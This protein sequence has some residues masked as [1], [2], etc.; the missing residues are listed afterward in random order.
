MDKVK[1]LAFNNVDRAEPD[2]LWRLDDPSEG[3]RFFQYLMDNAEFDGRETFELKELT[4]AEW[5]EAEK[6]GEELA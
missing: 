4:Q 1:V 5:A 2:D 3:Q 6:Y